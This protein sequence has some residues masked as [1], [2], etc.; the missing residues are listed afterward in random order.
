L[1]LLGLVVAHLVALHEVGSNNPDG[2]EIKKLKGEDGHPLDGIPFHPYYTVKDILGVVVFLMVFTAIV[3]FAPEMGGYFLE[4]NNFIPADSLKTPEHIAPVWYFTPYYA[5]LRAVPPILGSQFPG[6]ALMGVAVLIFFAM[7]WLDKSPVKS[8]RQRGPKFKIALT[9]F[10]IA[11]IGLGILGILP[12]TPLYTWIARI[13]SLV[14][15][16]FFFLMPWYTMN[17]TVKP[18]PERVTSK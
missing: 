13:L 2:V 14:Y 10:V 17:D 18:V 4:A 8:I 3:F 6:V 15:F 12:A 16:A 5:I 7:P 11:F 1:V 9:L